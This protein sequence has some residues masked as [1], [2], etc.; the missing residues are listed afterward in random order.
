MKIACANRVS[1]CP[2]HSSREPSQHNLSSGNDVC[3]ATDGWAELL[4]RRSRQPSEV[5]VRLAALAT[6]SIREASFLFQS[7]ISTVANT[8]MFGVPFR[9]YVHA[10]VRQTLGARMWLEANYAPSGDCPER[11]DVR[12]TQRKFCEFCRLRVH[13]VLVRHNCH[14]KPQRAKLGGLQAAVLKFLPERQARQV[15]KKAT[16]FANPRT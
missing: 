9:A 16:F 13:D 3:Q 5:S 10:G 11:L 1:Q 7:H 6:F 15:W 4:G 8:G 14:A 2:L 12:L